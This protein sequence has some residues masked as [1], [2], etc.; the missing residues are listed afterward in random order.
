[1]RKIFFLALA[2]ILVSSCEERQYEGRKTKEQ[3]NRYAISCVKQFLEELHDGDD[4][5]RE[6]C[7]LFEVGKNDSTTLYDV[8]KL[9]GVDW[10]PDEVEIDTTLEFVTDTAWDD[11]VTLKYVVVNTKYKDKQAKFA[12]IFNHSI[13]E[14]NGWFDIDGRYNGSE[15]KTI[16]ADSK[17]FLS[18]KTIEYSV[19]A[20]A[21]ISFSDK[22]DLMS[23]TL[24]KKS[25]KY[26]QITNSF[27]NSVRKGKPS[28]I[29]YPSGKSFG[30][31]LLADSLYTA[32]LKE[33]N[34]EFVFK[35]VVGNRVTLSNILCKIKYTND[36][37]FY[38]SY[39][40]IQD[41]KGIFDGIQ[42]CMAKY[43]KYE[44]LDLYP[45]FYETD[46]ELLDHI[47]SAVER[48]K[49]QEE[50]IRLFQELDR[51]KEERG[52]EYFDSQGNPHYKTNN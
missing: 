27:L 20:N 47:K 42:Y 11:D 39:G 12:V 37:S 40:E 45:A 18:D 51:I 49:S 16:I 14:G 38:L 2:I 26:L 21:Y 35:Y 17:G 36:I 31:F 19:K 29:H 7:A 13:Y 3:I 25:M 32:S 52:I 5:A 50:T 41:T 30:N 46:K 6:R 24:S 43:K 9:Q 44:L 15:G 4:D 28:Y 1:M 10:N 33:I 23:Y 34:F 48:K 22:W 8:A